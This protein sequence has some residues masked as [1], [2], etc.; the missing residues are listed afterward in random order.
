MCQVDIVGEELYKIGISKHDPEKRVKSLQTGNPNRIILIK[1]YQSPNYHKIERW[2]HRKF[3]IKKTRANGEWFALT[4]E[5]AN[6]FLQECKSIDSTVN[7]LLSEN[8]FYK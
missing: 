3:F 2:L 1:K 4:H 5:Q 8:P 7:Y 6:S